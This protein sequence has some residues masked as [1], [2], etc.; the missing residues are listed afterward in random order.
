MTDNLSIDNV[1]LKS[2]EFRGLLP[3]IPE[4]DEMDFTDKISARGA[5]L[6]AFQNLDEMF[7]I[8]KNFHDAIKARRS[9]KGYFLKFTLDFLIDLISF[10]N[11]RSVK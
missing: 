7:D 9:R 3:D 2:Y 4:I 6:F 10:E 5:I 1:A 11:F 8:I